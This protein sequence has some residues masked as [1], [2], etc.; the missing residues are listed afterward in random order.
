MEFFKLVLECL[1][2]AEA[3]AAVRPFIDEEAKLASLRYFQHI[4]LKSGY[5]ANASQA[6]FSQQRVVDFFLGGVK[7]KTGGPKHE[8]AYQAMRIMV[9]LGSLYQDYSDLFTNFVIPLSRWISHFDNRLVEA[10]LGAL[11]HVLETPASQYKFLECGGLA[12]LI[13][14]VSNLNQT[15]EEH[16]DGQGVSLT[17]LC[18]QRS[19][20]I[21]V[22]MLQN[23]DATKFI[24]DSNVVA[25]I[26][27]LINIGN[28]SVVNSWFDVLTNLCKLD[29][30]LK[31]YT[32]LENLELMLYRTL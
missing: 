21:L 28:L 10:A 7:D 13:Q 8:V 5:K 11:Y 9:D 22:I 14:C 3:P 2:P 6:S 30:F 32:T 15:V 1:L 25:P 17:T 12:A 24:L 27:N 16:S 4:I 29:D 31:H 18:L 26:L 20:Q 23:K 19:L